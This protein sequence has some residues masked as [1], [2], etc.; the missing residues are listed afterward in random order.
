MGTKHQKI[1]DP[2]YLKWVEENKNKLTYTKDS[3]VIRNAIRQ[4]KAT[5]EEA[6]KYLDGAACG[7][8]GNRLIRDGSAPKSWVILH[9]DHDEQFQYFRGPLCAI[10]NTMIGELKDDP[11]IALS[12]TI[13]L[14]KHLNERIGRKYETDDK[15]DNR[16]PSVLRKRP[17]WKN[18]N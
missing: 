3:L 15:V 16:L 14:F 4:K 18:K 13:Y 7:I 10:L 5:V 1:V 12:I 11:F 9:L 2:Y 8:S 17:I 6:I